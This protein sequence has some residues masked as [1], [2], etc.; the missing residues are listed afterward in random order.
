[1]P[2]MLQKGSA[3]VSCGRGSSCLEGGVL[4]DLAPRCELSE[5]T[6]KVLKDESAR[7]VDLPRRWGDGVTVRKGGRNA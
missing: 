6:D 7:V 3:Y 4:A 2:G 1:M 5:Q